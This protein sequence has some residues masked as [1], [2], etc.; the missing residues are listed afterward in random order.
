LGLNVPSLKYGA[1]RCGPTN[2]ETDEP[3]PTSVI[4]AL[5][6]FTR[7]MGFICLRVSTR[8]A[9]VRDAILELAITEEYNALP[10][11][12]HYDHE[13]I[14]QLGENE[15]EQFATLTKKVRYEIRKAEDAGYVIERCHSG[16]ELERL[17]QLVD[18]MNARKG[19][20][21]YA[22]PSW[23][24]VNVAC[25]AYRHGLGD[26]YRVCLD[27]DPVQ[28]LL[29]L[30][31]RDTAHYALGAV[32]I[33]AIGRRPSPSV[34]AHWK[35][36]RMSYEKG[37][38]RYNLGN[39]GDEALRV[40]K[41]KFRPEKVEYLPVFTAVLRPARYWAWKKLFPVALWVRSKIRRS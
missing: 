14:V 37:A 11:L 28:F 4:E 19:R 18:A 33:E 24:Y 20:R 26:L 13:L 8:E 40:F 32:D 41:R 2:L 36:M 39:E 5:L 38:R 34:W 10:L 15:D 9:L 31:D 3:V 35:A 30:R 6:R 1:L 29:V 12:G 7:E 23:S 22:R 16:E 21:I 17:W 27:G 25:L